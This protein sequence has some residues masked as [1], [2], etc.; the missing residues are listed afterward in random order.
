MP[1]PHARS[2]PIPKTHDVPH[3]RHPMLSLRHT[4]MDAPSPVCQGFLTRLP[5]AHSRSGRFELSPPPSDRSLVAHIH[6]NL[7]VAK[8][9]D[10]GRSC[11]SVHILHSIGLT[12]HNNNKHGKL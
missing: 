8:H 7:G 6:S 3:M 1:V 12:T 2:I 10:M 5:P 4:H 9:V 11:N